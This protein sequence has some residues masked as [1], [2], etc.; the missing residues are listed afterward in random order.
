MLICFRIHKEKTKSLEN[1]IDNLERLNRL[2]LA[3]VKA[4]FHFEF[5]HINLNHL[6]ISKKIVN[7]QINSLNHRL[8][9]L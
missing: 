8:K 7:N 5:N 1:K 3:K 2:L 4:K 9:S 6:G